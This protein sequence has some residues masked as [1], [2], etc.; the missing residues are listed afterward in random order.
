MILTKRH[1][2]KKYRFLL[3]IPIALVVICCIQSCKRETTSDTKSLTIGLETDITSLDP[4]KTLDPHVSRV[5]GQVFEGLVGLDENNRVIPLI[6]ESW[7][8]N[9]NF[10]QWRFVLRKGVFFHDSD[11]FGPAKTR[12]LTA[13]DVAFSFNRIFSK[14]SMIGFVLDGVIKGGADVKAG[15]TSTLSGVNII[16][17]Y[18]I[19][20]Q[21]ETP[22]PL[23]VNRLT[24]VLLAI[25]PR[26]AATLAKG[27]FGVKTT[28]GTGP[29]RV[30]QRTD[31]E[32]LLSRNSKYWRQTSGN[33]AKL[34]F[35]VIKN[36]QIRLVELKNNKIDLA[37]IPSA[38]ADG[39]AERVSDTGSDL[40]LRADWQ[41]FQF[42]IFRTF[43]VVALGFN[44]DKMDLHLRRAINFGIKRKDIIGLSLP[45]LTELAVGPI[46]LGFP[47]YKPVTTEDIYD[48]EKARAELKLSTS[49]VLSGPVEI[50]VH[51]KDGSEQV[52]QLIQAQL[53]EI[54]LETKLTKMDYNAV[55][56]R[57]ISGEFS[58]FIMAFEFIYSTPGPILE[59]NFNPKKIPVPNFWRYNNPAVSAVLEQFKSVK[60]SADANRLA[61]EIEK[62]VL[63]DPP[64]AFLFQ[65]KMFVVF[66]K[67]ISDVKFNGHS[68]PLLWETKVE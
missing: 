19:E 26:E 64:A 29:F 46:P 20:I 17:P 37:R 53:K 42:S 3:L 54:G 33:V 34:D 39:V 61:L 28:V 40:K 47:G 12:E 45:G 32:A 21:L 14:E 13:E 30:D 44:S 43:N 50:L 67:G 58:S 52:G 60:D 25:V 56:G 36:D 4:I 1:S 35:R 62:Q 10:D 16:S 31:S 38:L 22:D 55:I 65:N 49:P 57:M 27:E 2:M 48:P 51:E 15:K 24:S 9:E 66:R 8:P 7:K 18:E 11:L 41:G 5:V 68:V 63:D 6:A 23:F 59:M